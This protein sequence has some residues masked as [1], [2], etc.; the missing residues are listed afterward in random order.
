M[1]AYGAAAVSRH[2]MVRQGR[3]LRTHE[4]QPENRVAASVQ[5]VDSGAGTAAALLFEFCHV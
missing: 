4:Y 5:D 1:F 2:V 3:S